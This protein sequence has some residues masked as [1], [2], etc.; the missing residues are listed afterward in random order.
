MKLPTL[1]FG[2]FI[3][4]IIILIISIPIIMYAYGAYNVQD[5]I[6]WIA[7]AVGGLLAY[8]IGAS[9]VSNMQ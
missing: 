5:S 8:N 7:I 1:N 4:A 3:G 9:I 6:K 2:Q